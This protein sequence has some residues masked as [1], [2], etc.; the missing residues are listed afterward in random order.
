M[1]VGNTPQ[2]T[3]YVLILEQLASTGRQSLFT[4]EHCFSFPTAAAASASRLL[5]PHKAID[6]ERMVCNLQY[7]LFSEH[8]KTKHKRISQNNL[9]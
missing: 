4:E 1:P 7:T 8:G 9:W 2:H 5:S 3:T 6:S